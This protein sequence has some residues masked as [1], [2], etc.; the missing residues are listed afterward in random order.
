[1][2]ITARL[3]IDGLKKGIKVLAFDFSFNQDV[4]HRGKVNSNVRNG[5][6]NITIPGVD[7]PDIIQWMFGFDLLKDGKVTFSGFIDT[8]P[9]RSIEFK[10]AYLVYYHESYSESTDIVINLTISS[11]SIS[12]KGLTH[13][14]NW[15]PV[16]TANSE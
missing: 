16:E 5:L 9:H 13:E 4:D 12:V 11:Q 2:S 6:I 8:E 10:N 14:S 15:S 1:M 7:E 3:Y